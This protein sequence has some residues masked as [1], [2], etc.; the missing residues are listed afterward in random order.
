MS[1]GPGGDDGYV[2][3]GL[4]QTYNISITGGTVRGHQA[5]VSIGSEVGTAGAA[6]DYSKYVRNVTVTGVAG[7]NCAMIAYIKPGAITADYRDGL[8]ED[9]TISGCSLID[10]AGFLYQSAFQILAGRGCIVRNVNISDCTIR[11]RAR[12]QS[13]TNAHIYIAVNNVGTAGTV[14]DIVV[15]NVSAVDVYDGVANDGSHPG[16]P[17]D[18]AAF[19]ECP[20]AGFGSIKR[21]TVRDFFCRGTRIAGAYTGTLLTGPIRFERPIFR[22][23]ANNP[24]GGVQGGFYA[25]SEM[26]IYDAEVEAITGRAI[27]ADGLT[28]ATYKSQ[29]QTFHCGIFAAGNN[30]QNSGFV[31]PFDCYIWKIEITNNGAIAQSDVDYTTIELRNMNTGNVLVS[32]NTKVTGGIAVPDDTP[33]SLSATTLVGA[34]A[35]LPAGSALRWAKTDTG[36]GK[37]VNS[38]N[39]VVHFVPYS[40]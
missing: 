11:A 13:L 27:G 36:A 8:V 31:A 2:I 40:R 12:T 37:A 18:Y 34:N 30:G 20:T 33:I 21:I 24:P 17:I 39:V 19:I 28:A 26:G 10:P 38:M 29:K 3:K 6:G 14:E 25:G 32:A 35:I 15:S 23:I 22:K 5:I 4:A 7:Y 9:I 1:G 16:Y